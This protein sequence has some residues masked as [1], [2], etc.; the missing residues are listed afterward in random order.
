[1]SKKQDRTVFRNQDGDWANKRN[2]AGRT[3][4]LHP[5]QRD[6]ID[7]AREM[8]GNQ[9]GAEIAVKGRNGRIR[10]KDTIPPG[11]DPYPPKDTEH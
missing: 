1:M 8:L 7:A 9:G 2:D 5:T 10:S 6:A 4:S 11:N 3:S